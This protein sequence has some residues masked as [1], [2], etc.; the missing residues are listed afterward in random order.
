M[1][2]GVSKIRKNC[3]CRLWMVPRPE[4]GRLK[5]KMRECCYKLLFFL[6]LYHHTSYSILFVWRRK[7]R[8]SIWTSVYKNRSL[9]ENL[10]DSFFSDSRNLTQVIFSVSTLVK[11][12]FCLFSSKLFFHRS[13]TKL[14]TRAGLAEPEGQK[15]FTPPPP[16]QSLADQ[17][18]RSKPGGRGQIIPTPLLLAPQISDLPPAL[19]STL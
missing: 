16:F 9:F 19:E 1:R 10:H 5:R 8:K 11:K 18:T 7:G 13:S 3:R 14:L 2:E 4:E 15:A 12:N 17:L 6:G